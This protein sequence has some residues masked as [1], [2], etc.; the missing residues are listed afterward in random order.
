VTKQNLSVVP[1]KSLGIDAHVVYRISK[2]V[3]DLTRCMHRVNKNQPGQ[4]IVACNI[5]RSGANMSFDIP[6][7][8]C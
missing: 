7:D 6:A 4:V 2:A 5:D 3:S 8:L 1:G